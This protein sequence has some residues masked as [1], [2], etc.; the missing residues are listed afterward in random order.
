MGLTA[1]DTLHELWE[2]PE[3]PRLHH[4]SL[5]E[6]VFSPVFSGSRCRRGTAEALAPQAGLAQL[7]R[8]PGELV[9]NTWPGFPPSIFTQILS[10]LT[11]Q[12]HFLSPDIIF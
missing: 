9:A 11:P 1:P 5:G 2:L 8:L 4:G 12:T 3:A 10:L 7:G 6:G